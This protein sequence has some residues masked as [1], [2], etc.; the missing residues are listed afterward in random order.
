MLSLTTQKFNFYEH[1]AQLIHQEIILSYRG[2]LNDVLLAELGHGIRVSS[3]IPPKIGKKIFTI[4]MELAQNVLYYS[5]EVNHYGDRDRVG[6]LLVFQNSAYYHILTA[7]LIYAKSIEALEHKCRMVN[8]LDK[9]GLRDYKRELRNA[10]PGVES[11]GAGIGMVQAAIISENL[12]DYDFK[13]L[14]EEYAFYTISAK[15]KIDSTDS[16]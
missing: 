13:L 5:Q 3:V 10:P 14:D 1:Q 9:D 8:T 4:F 7:N 2:P 11:R 12:I 16:E 6:T 15:V